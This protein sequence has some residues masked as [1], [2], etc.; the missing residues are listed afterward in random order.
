MKPSPHSLDVCRSSACAPL[1]SL[2]VVSLPCS[3]FDC[4]ACRVPAR[5]P[6]NF[7]LRGQMK[8]TK[9]KALNATPLMRSASV[10]TPAQRATWIR[11]GTSNPLRTR[12]RGTRNASPALIR[13]TQGRCEARTR[14]VRCR[15]DWR[16]YLQVARRAGCAKR[17]ER[18]EWFCIEGL[19]FGDFH[20][21]PQMKVT[22]PPGRD[23]A[24]WQAAKAVN[25]L[26]RQK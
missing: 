13:S 21:A 19:C 7:H 14:R 9:A 2:A 4:V 24:G 18:A 5:R 16:R 26:E 1:R 20:L 25:P 6:G 15:F 17:E 8:V 10:G 3:L 12:R 23:P 11:R 22:R